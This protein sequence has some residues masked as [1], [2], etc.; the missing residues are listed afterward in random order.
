MLASILTR[1]LRDTL[2]RYLALAFGI[3][4]VLVSGVT[5]EGQSDAKISLQIPE[6]PLK[7]LIQNLADEN[8]IELKMANIMGRETVEL[9]I[10]DT[11]NNIFTRLLRKYN[12]LIRYDRGG[13]ILSVTIFSAKDPNNSYD[14][15]SLPTGELMRDEPDS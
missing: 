3:L 15:S 4:L 1:F 8:D 13:K 2:M 6:Q 9:E 5:A 10:N 14:E 7:T 12:H 11:L